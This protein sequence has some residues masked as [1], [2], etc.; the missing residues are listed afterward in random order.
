MSDLILH[1]YDGSPFSEKVRLILGF[2]SL[3]WKSVKVPVMLP[4]PDVVALTGGYRRTPFLQMGADIYCDTA[5]MSRVI[6]ARAPQPPLYPVA[7]GGAQH[8]LAQWADSTLFWT[9]IPYTMQ[10]VGAAY[11]FN[12]A[13][14]DFLKAFGADRAAMTPNLRR[15]TVPDAFAQL[16]SYFGWLESEFT[17]GRAFLLGAKPCIADFSVAQ[18]IWYIR[19][20][21]PVASVLAPFHKLIAWY[22]RMAAFG[23]GTPDKMMSSDAI[24]LAASTTHYAATHVEEGAGFAAGDAVTVAAIDYA[25]DLVPGTLVGLTQHEMVIERTDERAGKLHVHF[26]RI[27]YQIKKPKIET[28]ANT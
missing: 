28:G 2:K 5:L 8:L 14:P 18:S 16:T 10:P 12:G 7:A 13:P 4:K 6:D 11:L 1:H 21:P 15:A 3:A 22:E 23:H 20:A 17:D 9:A 27:G 25:T 26:P 19:R 24:D